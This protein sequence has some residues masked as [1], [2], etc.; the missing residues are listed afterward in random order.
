MGGFMREIDTSLEAI[1]DWA[2]REDIGPGDVTTESIVPSDLRC[3]AVLLAKADG[4]LSGMK[5]FCAIFERLG[6]DCVYAEQ[7]SDGCAFRRGDVLARFTGPARPILTGERTA[8]NFVQHLSGVATL[9][10]A[11]VEAVRGLPVKICDTRKT[12]PGLRALEKEAV[13]HGGGHNHRF[14]LYDGVLIKD[15]HIVAAGGIGPAVR[16]ARERAHHLL[17]I[18]V[19]AS[20]LSQVREALDAGADAIL[21]DNMDLDTLRTAVRLAKDSGALLEASGNVTLERVRAIAETGV[22]V[23]SAGALTHSARAI[24]ISLELSWPS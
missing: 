20:N 6:A 17:K 3:A 22:H 8:V 13:R 1:V 9:T 2:L 12:T 19:E 5:V 18:E 24:D 14:A 21:L 4:V 7:K 23:I 16:L 10:A 11:Y 15:N